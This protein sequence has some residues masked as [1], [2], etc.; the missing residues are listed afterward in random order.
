MRPEGVVAEYRD[1]RGKRRYVVG[2][3][4]SRLGAHHMSGRTYERI[5]GYGDTPEDAIAM[6]RRKLGVEL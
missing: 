3:W 4:H 5:L 2:Y 6:M 1:Y